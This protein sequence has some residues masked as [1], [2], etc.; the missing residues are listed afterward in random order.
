[1]VPLSLR[2]AS[3]QPENEDA[4]R[5]ALPHVPAVFRASS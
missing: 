3:V 1:V 5:Y 4:G 2:A